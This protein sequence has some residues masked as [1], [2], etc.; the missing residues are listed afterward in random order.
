MFGSA[1]NQQSTGFGSATGGFGSTANN[2][3]GNS[4]FG[5][6][7]P[8]TGS[9][10]FGS[11]NNTQATG[12][13]LFGSAAPA[14][15]AFG[16]SS[17]G[18]NAFGATNTNTGFGAN[19]NQQK[20]GGFAFGTQP[21]ATGATGAFGSTTN[22]GFGATNTGT[23]LFGQQ[24]QQQQPAATGFG[25][26]TTSNAFGGTGAFGATNTQ[27]T[28]PFGGATSAFGAQQPKPAFGTGFGTATSAA[29]ASTGLFGSAPQAQPQQQ[30]TGLF[31]SKPAFG[32]TP[33]A[34]STGLFGSAQP[35]QTT[36]LFGNTQP[37]ATTGGGLFGSNPTTTAP[38]TGLFGTAQTQA[39][40]SLF[41]STPTTQTG[42]FGSAAAQPATSSL[43]G[44]QQQ[45]QQQTGLFG[46]FGQSQQVQQQ[47]QF[48]TSIADSP[49]GNS[50]LGASQM[51]SPLGPIA[52][53]LGSSQTKKAAMIP[54]H[55]IAPRQPALTPRLNNSFSRSGSPFASSTMG[56]S[57]SAGSLGRSTSTNN[58]LSLFDSDD[59]ILNAGAFSSNGN[60]RV[61]SLKRLVIDKKIK[62]QDLFEESAEPRGRIENGTPRA[63]AT[64]GILKKTVSFDMAG[65]K[66]ADEDLFGT[67]AP[68][69]PTPTAEELGYVRSTPD[70]RRATDIDESPRRSATPEVG[71][72]I[73][74]EV[75]V[76]QQPK[77]DK[78]HG[79]YWMVPNAAKL[80]SLTR[81]QQ[82]KVI[83]LTIGRRGYGS[84]RFDNP[85]DITGI[86]CEIEEIPGTVVVFETRVC[87]VYPEHL[88]KPSPGKGLNVPATISLE[89][90]YPLTKNQRD[91]ITDPEHPRYITHIRRLKSIKDTEFV[92][93]SPNNGLWI[94]KVRHFTT[95]GLVD[96]DEGEI[97]EPSF[98]TNATPT[99]RQPI[100]TPASLLIDDNEGIVDGD[101]SGLSALSGLSGMDSI[102]GLDD[103]FEFRRQG[104]T[105]L[106]GGSGDN[107]AGSFSEEGGSYEEEVTFDEGATFEEGDAT[108]EGESFLGEGSVGS[109][110]E[111]EE[112]AEPMS[113]GEEG[114]D[115]SVQ[116]MTV[117]VDDDED[118][119][120]MVDKGTPP[121]FVMPPADVS[122]A[123]TITEATPK[124]LA[125]GRDWTEQLN[126]TISPVKRR[127]GGENRFSVSSRTASPLK[128][129]M[130]PLNYGLLDLAADL[131][132]SP[133]KVPGSETRK[134][135]KRDQFEV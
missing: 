133:S 82:K 76:V 3:A 80:K 103:T 91:K 43:F 78:S 38:S 111:D 63:P 19:A 37:A 60:S 100:V 52:T 135:R 49:Y 87:T 99:P 30:S 18:T 14:T 61:A 34:P 36:S 45:P 113:E 84:I 117:I 122:P 132:G 31:G 131:W 65:D 12:T 107:F 17:A 98:A 134:T 97:Q 32:A 47:Q 81:E 33:A 110:E 27:S 67:G 102:S 127:F 105:P 40:P 75:A 90:C 21:A 11:T 9:G 66:A 4:L 1:N 115:M 119:T 130:Q 77:D 71:Q 106:R 2:T 118:V 86:P 124:A 125:M 104:G 20:P 96:D 54:H 73:G 95:Y 93:Y 92:E 64:K 70:K 8:A 23:G 112:P 59:S 24:Q 114:D 13:G 58:K 62:D 69:N 25:A 39:K 56:S 28:T 6:P 51:A 72:V 129:T 123:G 94:F 68:I 121:R 16:G 41:S 46:S 53:P 48:T 10:L 35:Q 42:L 83:G 44:Q 79:T 108:M 55:K 101:I 126:N 88:E 128:A 50:L 109:I 22:T 74:N 26:A 120:G 15:N 7:K 29:P 116:E 5:A 85:V 57:V 89:E